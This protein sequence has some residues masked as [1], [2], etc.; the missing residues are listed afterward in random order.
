M[1]STKLFRK[2]EVFKVV[3]LSMKAAEERDFLS[4]FLTLFPA[5]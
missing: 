3:V 2:H 4:A 5:I 1:P